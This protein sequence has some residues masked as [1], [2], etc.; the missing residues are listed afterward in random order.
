MVGHL[1]LFKPAVQKMIESIRAG[2]IGELYYISMCRAKLGKVRR[3]ED[4]LWSFA[5]HESCGLAKTGELAV[6][7][8]HRCRKSSAATAD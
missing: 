4:V 5:P 8:R 1:L 6:R 3:E 7:E 2:L